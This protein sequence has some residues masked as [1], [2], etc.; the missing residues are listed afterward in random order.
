[1]AF[2]PDD[3]SRFDPFHVHTTTYKTIHSHSITLNILIPRTLTPSPNGQPIILRYHGGG[4]IASASMFPDF[5]ARWLLDL[6]RQHNA[7]IISPDYRLLPEADVNDILSD[8]D[9]SFAWLHT[10]LQPY[11]DSSA[12]GIKA[13]TSRIV[14]AGESAGGYLSLITSLNHPNEVRATIASYPMVDLNAPWFA[15]H[16]EKHFF[17]VPQLPESVYTEHIAKI[18]AQEDLSST[19]SEQAKKVVV[20]SDPRLDR[21]PLF[22]AMVQHGSFPRH[23]DNSNKKGLILDRLEG[24]ERFPRGGVFVLHG[25]EDSLVPVEQSRKLAEKVNEVDA[26]A[27]FNLVERPGDHGFDG[28]T[29]LDEEWLQD[30]LK[31]IVD[32]WLA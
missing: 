13:D 22:F 25:T 16:F 6:A 5:F 23:L 30:G 18:K 27:N 7:I 4:L 19:S 29:K 17:D 31:P 3:L 20:S 14:T 21:A 28:E 15:E 12:N 10:N 11:L 1:M 26:D 32:A 9:D 8:I 2:N 24:G